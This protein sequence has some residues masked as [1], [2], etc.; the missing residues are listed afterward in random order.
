[1]SPRL[2]AVILV[3]SAGCAFHAQELPGQADASMTMADAA[4]AVDVFTPDGPPID[5]VTAVTSTFDTDNPIGVISATV[6]QPGGPSALVIV[7]N[8]LTIAGTVNVSGS[9]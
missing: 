4:V 6:T 8:N 3:T 1:M 5:D 9:K 7:Y 2:A